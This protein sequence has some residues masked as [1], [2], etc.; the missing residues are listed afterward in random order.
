MHPDDKR[1]LLI[2]AGI[3]VVI[4]LF[5]WLGLDIADGSGV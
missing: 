2:V 5:V 1:F 3:V 4:L